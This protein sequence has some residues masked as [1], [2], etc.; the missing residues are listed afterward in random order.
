MQE[1]LR[2]SLIMKSSQKYKKI[3]RK[4]K[5]KVK[6]ERG[7]MKV[8]NKEKISRYKE[9]IES[10]KKEEEVSSLPEAC[11]E[12]RN[13]RVFSGQE[14]KSEPLNDPFISSPAIKLSDA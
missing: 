14:I 1:K 4:L 7:K 10:R 3:T 2:E 11:R 12:F 13:L 6:N 9:R 5:G 8:K